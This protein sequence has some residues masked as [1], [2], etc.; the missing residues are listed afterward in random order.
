MPLFNLKCDSWC[1]D[2]QAIAPKPSGSILHLTNRQV[3]VDNFPPAVVVHMLARHLGQDL[4]AIRR[5]ARAILGRRMVPLPLASNLT[6]VPV[7]VSQGPGPLWAYIVFERAVLYRHIEE[8]P[9]RTAISMEDGTTIRTLFTPG[10]LR[11]IWRE[12]TTAKRDAVRPDK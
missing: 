7:R 4:S 3:E 8:V 5:R 9:M 1:E 10:I 2:I 12:T 6:L 11:R